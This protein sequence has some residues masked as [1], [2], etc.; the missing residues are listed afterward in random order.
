M[1]TRE[2]SG[3]PKP[4]RK[5]YRRPTLEKY[6]SVRA[7]TKISGGTMGAND[8]VQTKNKTGL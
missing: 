3:G 7:L 8:Q 6:G 5:P 4:P 1:N 2:P